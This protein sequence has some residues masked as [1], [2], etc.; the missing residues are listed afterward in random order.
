MEVKIFLGMLALGACFCGA[1]L[2]QAQTTPK[3]SATELKLQAL[4]MG[5]T[6]FTRKN[7]VVLTFNEIQNFVSRERNFVLAEMTLP[8][9]ENYEDYLSVT[10]KVLA[11]ESEA[12][13]RRLAAVIAEGEALDRQIAQKS[14]LLISNYTILV[15]HGKK[16]NESDKTIIERVVSREQELLKFG[17]SPETF[18][19]A[20]KLLANSSAFK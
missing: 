3:P 11:A 10:K 17:A 4:A 14:G 2:V 8:E 13:D 20:K 1:G 15:S 18:E 16:L 12:S 9:Y 7:G 5:Q 19:K 6:T